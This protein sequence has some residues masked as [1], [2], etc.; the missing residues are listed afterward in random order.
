MLK[1]IIFWLRNTAHNFSMKLGQYLGFFQHDWTVCGKEKTGEKGFTEDQGHVPFH[2]LYTRLGQKLAMLEHYLEIT[3]I[4]L[5]TRHTNTIHWRKW[6]IPD[7]STTV[8]STTKTT[9][10]P[11]L[12]LQ[13]QRAQNIPGDV[14]SFAKRPH[15]LTAGC[16]CTSPEQEL[17]FQISSEF[18]SH[19]LMV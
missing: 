5:Q 11:L 9:Y 7:Q 16:N 6:R 17:W 2:H 10:E 12:L 19:W 14:S 1:S 4:F 18:L 15:F 8:T 3:N 13:N